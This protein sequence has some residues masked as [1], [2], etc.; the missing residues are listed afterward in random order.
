MSPAE[1]QAAESALKVAGKLL[2]GLFAS[3]KHYH[4]Y[5]WDPAL[6]AWHFVLD[7]HPAQVNPKAESYAASGLIVAVV[8][9]KN[10]AAPDGTLAPKDPPA[11][12][13][14]SAEAVARAVSLN[15]LLMVAIV[16]A[17]LFLFLLLRGRGKRALM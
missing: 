6:N 5:Y 10:D 8:R 11:G 9:N 16:G 2:K 7:G 12:Y 3:K 17:G 13:T 14:A 15:P 1:V 4:L